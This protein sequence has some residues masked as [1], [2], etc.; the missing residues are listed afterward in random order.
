MRGDADDRDD[1]V[2]AEK[3]VTRLVDG[4]E[5]EGLDLVS[6][7]ARPRVRHTTL[8]ARIRRGRVRLRRL[9]AGA[10]RKEKRDKGADGERLRGRRNGGARI[11]ACPPGEVWPT[12]RSRV[13][14]R[15]P[16]LSVSRFTIAPRGGSMIRRYSSV[17]VPRNDG[18]GEAHFVSVRLS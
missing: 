4:A 13:A 1:L 16:G 5:A 10:D 7:R 18:V 3:I 17:K 12:F 15:P 2:R 14:H 6:S 8:D 9:G 11:M